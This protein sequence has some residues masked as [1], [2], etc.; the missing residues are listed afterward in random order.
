MTVLTDE[1]KKIIMDSPLSGIQIAKELGVGHTTVTVYRSSH[2]YK[3]EHRG[4]VRG[5]RSKPPLKKEVRPDK[6]S[7]FSM[8]LINS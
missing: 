2:G 8:K 6:N 4:S 5:D 3:K 7:F 1:M